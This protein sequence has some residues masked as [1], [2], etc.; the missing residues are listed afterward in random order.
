MASI[1]FLNCTGSFITSIGPVEVYMI[2]G[3]MGL[4]IAINCANTGIMQGLYI[5]LFHVGKE[6]HSGF[7]QRT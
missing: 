7:K 3:I 2:L 1:G 5:R 4:T 6:V